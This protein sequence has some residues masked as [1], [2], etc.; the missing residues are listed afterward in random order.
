MSKVIFH[1][2]ECFKKLIMQ[3]SYPCNIIVQK[4]NDESAENEDEL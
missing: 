3:Q 1:R 2:T 4:K